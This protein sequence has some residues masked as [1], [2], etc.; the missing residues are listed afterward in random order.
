MNIIGKQRVLYIY[1]EPNTK[2]TTLTAQVLINYYGIENIGFISKNKNFTLEN[3][4]NKEIAI[5][6]EYE[7][8]NL[9]IDSALKL[10]EGSDIIIDQ[11]FKKPIILNQLNLI[12]ISNNPIIEN[13][14]ITPIIKEA[15]NKRI[16]Y[17]KFT[18]IESNTKNIIEINKQL[19]QEEPFIIL[20]CNKILHKIKKPQLK[21]NDKKLIELLNNEYNA[22]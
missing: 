5:F 18:K 11:K 10:L 21:L 14:N 8:Y 6:D 13:K 17:I 9:P 19:I 22:N 3:L 7:H 2:K 12:I 15:L 20:Y 16:K 4:I 1:G